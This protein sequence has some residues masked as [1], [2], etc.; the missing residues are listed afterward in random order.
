MGVTSLKL[1]LVLVRCFL[2]PPG[3]SGPKAGALWTHS[4]SIVLTEGIT[5]LWLPN[6]PHIRATCDIT[7][8]VKKVA[9]TLVV[10]A[11]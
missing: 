2:G 6:H 4:C 1:V 3:L 7:V 5:H 11:S 9:E 10:L 8:A